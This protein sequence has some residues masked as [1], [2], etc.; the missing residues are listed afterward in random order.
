VLVICGLLFKVGAFPFHGWV[1]DVYQGAILPVTA[2]MAAAVKMSA[3]IV[4]GKVA[5]SA[6]SDVNAQE[7]IHW[8]VTISAILT[9][10]YGNIVALTQKNLKKLLAYSSI[11]HT[12]Y[13]MVGILSLNQGG[14][15]AIYLYLTFYVF[16]TLGTFAILQLLFPGDEEATI[17]Q[18]NGLGLSH[19]LLGGLLTLFFLAMAG[20]PI[21]SGF[22]GKY[23]VFSAGVNAGNVLLVIFAV[24]TS[25]VATFYY[26]RVIVALYFNKASSVLSTRWAM[27]A[28]VVAI[29][30]GL[31]T[32]HFGLRP[33]TLINYF[34][35]ESPQTRNL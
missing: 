12:G 3:F 22:I 33:N 30:C 18:L 1:P 8:L 20:I 35:S 31:A 19:P 34:T 17:E 9:M 15:A 21:T 16:T 7:L 28:L 23:L 24:L 4:L 5:T 29:I 2:I 11:A 14:Q 27:S 10:A 25:V 13:L 26:L 32:L 6:L